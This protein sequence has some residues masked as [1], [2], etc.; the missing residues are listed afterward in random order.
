M[1]INQTITYEYV[2]GDEK[3]YSSTMCLKTVRQRTS[4][5]GFSSL[6]AFKISEAKRFSTNNRTKTYK[7]AGK[8][9]GYPK[10]CINEF[11]FVD[12]DKRTDNQNK[13]MDGRGFVP[14][15]KHAD[16]IIEGTIT[17]DELIKKRK[18]RQKFP[19]E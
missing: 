2:G 8:N 12:Y 11:C 14:C 16:L 5:A 9:Y 15:A 1:K 6:L 3:V 13:V 10:C 4:R 18:N 19:I 17:M 7:R